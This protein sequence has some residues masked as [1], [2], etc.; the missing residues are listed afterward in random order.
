MSREPIRVVAAVIER[1]GKYLITQRRPTAVLPLLWEFPGGKVEAGESDQDAL[2]RELRYRLAAAVDVGAL[3]SYVSH[4]YEHY[5]VDL[6]LYE[7]TLHGDEVRAEGVHAF[8]WVASGDFEKYPFTPAD[9]TSMSKL[10]GV[11]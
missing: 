9:E 3:I 5:V 6:Y 7:C 11:G 8:K 1:D 10:L 4:P 2:R